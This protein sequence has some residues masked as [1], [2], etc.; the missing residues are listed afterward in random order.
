M[1]YSVADPGIQFG[2]TWRARSASL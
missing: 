1:L 2:G